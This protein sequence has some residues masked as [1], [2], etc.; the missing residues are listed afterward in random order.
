MRRSDNTAGL[1]FVRGAMSPH[2]P[3]VVA[4]AATVFVTAQ[5]QAADIDELVAKSQ[6]I[7][8]G[9]VVGTNASTMPALTGTKRMAIVRV[10]EVFQAPASLVD[11]TG[12]RVTVLLSQPETPKPPR[13]T[14]F[15]TNGWLYGTSLA[16]IE[17]G[18]LD[19]H[20]PMFSYDLL[21]QAK[22][23][24]ADQRLRERIRSAELVVVGIV[25]NVEEPRRRSEG[26]L[27]SEHDP[28]WRKANIKVVEVLMGQKDTREVTILF[29]QSRDVQW[30]EAPKFAAGQEGVW[31]LR[32]A[33]L[34]GLLRRDYL[35]VL[36]PDDFWLSTELDRIRRL[37]Q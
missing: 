10:K 25:K 6:I 34:P 1:I 21:A 32:R 29:A 16:L 11:L 36:D 18:R 15:F 9:T 8:R 26:G 22:G 27:K 17:T 20:A 31:L 28:D 30:A 19:G 33:T 5:A 14:V 12:S 13:D 3:V 7:F 2:R 24:I 35:T 4:W 37:L 23:R